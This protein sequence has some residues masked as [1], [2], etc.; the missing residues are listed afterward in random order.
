[1]AALAL[2]ACKPADAPA[3]AAPAPAPAAPTSAA[4][5]PSP[6]APVAASPA[7]AQPAAITGYTHPEGQDLFGYYMP[8]GEVKFGKWAMSSLNIGTLE[9]MVKFE[10]GERDPPNYAP[11]NIEFDDVT[12]PQKENELGGTYYT[13]SRR[14]LPLAYLIDD[15]RLVFI[16]R[17]DE[18]GEV[19]FEGHLDIPAVK[20]ATADDTLTSRGAIVLTG[21]LTVGSETRKVRFTWFGGD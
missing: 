15:K 19:R 8:E 3:P 9:E 14:V 5:A 2:F 11:V 13:N 21:D 4:A 7:A 6:A 18:L 20:R 1:V 12:S 17:D 10:K 16:G